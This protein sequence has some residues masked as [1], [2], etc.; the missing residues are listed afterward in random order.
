MNDQIPC[1]IIPDSDNVI[2]ILKQPR[3]Y[4]NNTLGAELNIKVKDELIPI[5]K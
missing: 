1:E 5:E 4:Y 3:V 2:V